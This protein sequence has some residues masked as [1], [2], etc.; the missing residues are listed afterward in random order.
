MKITTITGTI[1]FEDE[2][3]YL[4]DTVV[5]AVKSGAHLS[6]AHLRYA[7]LRGTD[8]SGADLSGAD[9]SCADLS[10]AD[11]RRAELSGADLSGADLIFADLRGAALRCA[12]LG[13]AKN[14]PFIPLACP[15]DGEFTGWKKVG[16]KLIELRIP[17]EARRSSATTDKCRCDKALVVS[18]FDIE[19]REEYV[20]TTNYNYAKTTY[21]VGELVYPDSFDENRWNECS[22]GIHFFINK[23]SAINH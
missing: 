13:G 2:K 4:K 15:S 14:I 8:L 18:I 9:L 3:E 21:R 7:D 12:N 22:H 16:E 6:G 1:L 11:L 17:A 5:H 19:T 20:E 23:G 10:C